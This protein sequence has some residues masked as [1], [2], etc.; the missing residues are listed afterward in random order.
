M[1]FFLME[2]ASK[3]KSLHFYSCRPKT[4]SPN[5]YYSTP[6]L[7]SCKEFI[8]NAVILKWLYYFVVKGIF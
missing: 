4:T 7:N 6:S 8:I 1:C 3:L 2:L 5:E